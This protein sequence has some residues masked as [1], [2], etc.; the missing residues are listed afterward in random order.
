MA[1]PTEK[2][3]NQAR[4]GAL[5]WFAGAAVLVGAGAAG[6]YY[7]GYLATL[8]AVAVVG[9]PALPVIG[10][11]AGVAVI[12]APVIGYRRNKTSAIKPTP[13]ETRPSASASGKPV[14]SR[15]GL[16]IAAMIALP[17]LGVAAAVGA[18]VYFTGSVAALSAVVMPVLPVVGIAVAAVA[19]LAL[20]AV[21]VRAI[22][23]RVS[24]R[25][26]ARKALAQLQSEQAKVDALIGQIVKQ[27]NECRTAEELDSHKAN[28]SNNSLYEQL[29]NALKFAHLSFIQYAAPKLNAAHA[30]KMKTFSDTIA[31]EALDT[32]QPPVTHQQEASR[33]VDERDVF[34]D[35]SNDPNATVNQA[36]RAE[37]PNP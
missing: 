19:G 16:R 14:K 18:G 10:A 7:T 24:A 22:A 13:T 34:H 1:K 11:V 15:K 36:L 26:P 5:R 3:G 27:I 31:Q 35:A 28:F 2:I 8:A 32:A 9:V 33:S 4:K 12:A 30:E 20:V 37:S 17:I 21:A 6:L 23:R 25:K 29:K